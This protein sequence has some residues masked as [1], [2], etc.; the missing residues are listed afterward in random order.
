M[1][2]LPTY[3][4]DYFQAKALGTE[5][6][7]GIGP[8]GVRFVNLSDP[9]LRSMGSYGFETIESFDYDSDVRDVVYLPFWNRFQV[10]Y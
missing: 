3:G 10:L 6:K 9:D 8:E 2:E 5:V 1:Y 7:I 4:R